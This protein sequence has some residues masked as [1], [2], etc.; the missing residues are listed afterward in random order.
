MFGAYL[1][2]FIGLILVIFGIPV[3]I[4]GLFSHGYLLIGFAMI[5]G[6]GFLRYLSSQTARTVD[7]YDDE[8]KKQPGNLTVSF[9]TDDEGFDGER[10]IDDD[11]YQ[12]YLVEKY[13]IKKNDTLN[14]F[15]LK[16]K[17]FGTLEDALRAA[18]DL[19]EGETSKVVQSV[20]A[21]TKRDANDVPDQFKD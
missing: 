10:S 16:R 12:L 7:M 4:I 19:E 6:G 1:Q 2:G 8:S 9:V 20:A 14:K 15:V 17:S 21:E 5:F 13:S 11:E 18:H 3:F